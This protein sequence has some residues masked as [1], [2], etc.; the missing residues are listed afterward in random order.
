MLIF[1][2]ARLAFLATPKTGTTAIEMALRQKAEI[3]FQRG[4][5]HMPA[6]RFHNKVAPFIASTFDET[7]ETVALM[8]E[9]LAQLRSWYRYRA[10]DEM[11]GKPKSTQSASFAQFVVDIAS[12]NPPEY[13]QING[14]MGFLC[15]NGT[16]AVDHLFAYENLPAFIDF[17][18]TRLG[19][20]IVLKQKN[21]S[22]DINADLTELQKRQFRQTR[23]AEYALYNRLMAA[24]GYLRNL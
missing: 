14:Q 8:R 20:E 19:T 1:L 9:P 3:V 6:R 10:R 7:L 13:A 23:K 24:G 11:A 21:V 2:E 22:P 4:R 15:K 5:K 12:P 18:Q 16:L 17:M